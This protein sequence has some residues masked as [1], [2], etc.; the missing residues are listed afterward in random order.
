MFH[1][2]AIAR[3]F[4]AESLLAAYANG[5]FAMGDEDGVVHWIASDPRF[6]LPV[7]GLH[8][9]RS[10]SRLWRRR[11]FELKV[12]S[13]FRRVME[14]CAEDRGGDNLNWITPRMIDVYSEAHRMGFAHSVEA[15]QG[16][17]LV[18]GLY[19]VAIGGA[20]FGESMFTRRDLGVANASKICLL[21]LDRRLVA[22]GYTLLDSQEANPH[23]RQFGGVEIPFAAYAERLGEALQVDASL[24]QAWC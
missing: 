2:V 6:V 20:F 15:W 17:V 18:G 24:S 16:G 7:G 9:P 14:L 8:V 23:M 22:G 21:E 19:G 5:L 12:D 11:P 1:H 3:R 4:D 10:L 13:A